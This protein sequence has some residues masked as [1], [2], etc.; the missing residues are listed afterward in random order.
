MGKRLMRDL[1][2]V[3]NKYKDKTEKYYVLVHAK[4][5]PQQPNIIKI[6]LIPTNLKPPMMLS[7]LLFG[8][9]NSNGTLTLE[10]SLPGSWPVWSVGGTQEPIPEVIG[11]LKE[12]EKTCNI[13]S[14]IAY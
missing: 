7:C 1:E 10:W 4:P 11:S 8:V 14:V 5:F 3:V 9:D 2:D 13:D 12:L 6:K